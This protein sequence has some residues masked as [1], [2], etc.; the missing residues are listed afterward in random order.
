MEYCYAESPIINV[1]P[2][3]APQDSLRYEPTTNVY[4]DDGTPLHDKLGRW[5]SLLVFDDTEVD[6]MIVA[7][8]RWDI[9]VGIVR[10]SDPLIAKIYEANLVLVRPDQHVSWR[11]SSLKDSSQAEAVLMRSL[12]WGA[13][14]RRP[15]AMGVTI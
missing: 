11:G 5:F 12:G 2:Q 1:E 7:A 9:P 14:G 13:A 4:L 8:R 6:S 3:W 15:T 10:V